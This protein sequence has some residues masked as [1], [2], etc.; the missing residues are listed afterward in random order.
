MNDFWWTK[1]NL[2][3]EAQISYRVEMLIA[4]KLGNEYNLE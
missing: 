3:Q 1:E 2:S 4:S